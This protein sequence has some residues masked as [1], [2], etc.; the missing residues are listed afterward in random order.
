M[1]QMLMKVARVLMSACL[2]VGGLHEMTCLWARVR[3]RVR[4]G[5]WGPTPLSFCACVF[6]CVCALVRMCFCGRVCLCEAVSVCIV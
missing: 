6:V 3:L 2:C 1:I 4:V 5:D